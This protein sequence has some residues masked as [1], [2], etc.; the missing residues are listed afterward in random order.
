MIVKTY[1]TC[2]SCNRTSTV[3]KKSFLEG[4]EYYSC[5]ECRKWDRKSRGYVPFEFINILKRRLKNTELVNK[6]WNS[7]SDE[8]LSLGL[9]VESVECVPSTNLGKV[10]KILE[11]S[12]YLNKK[13]FTSKV[14]VEG[15]EYVWVSVHSE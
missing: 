4:R 9:N 3:D 6:I 10:E 12:P 5:S 2:A 13:V 14:Y 1:N 8:V 15:K 11:R 7:I